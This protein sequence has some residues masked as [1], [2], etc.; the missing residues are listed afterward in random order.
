MLIA[1]IISLLPRDPWLIPN[2]AAHQQAVDRL[3]SFVG[4]VDEIHISISE[5]PIF[6]DPGVGLTHVTCP[7]CQHR[8][9]TSWQAIVDWAAEQHFRTLDIVM[10]CCRTSVSL[11]DLQYDCPAGWARFDIEAVNPKVAQLSIEQMRELEQIL[12]CPMRQLLLPIDDTET[13]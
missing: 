8:F 12:D 13:A 4:E 11:N 2:E 9:T 3:V 6:I 1:T 5:T 10:P 7:S